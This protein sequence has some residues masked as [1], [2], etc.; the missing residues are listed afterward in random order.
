M[1]EIICP[2]FIDLINFC[3]SKIFDCFQCWRDIFYLVPQVHLPIFSVWISLISSAKFVAFQEVSKQYHIAACKLCCCNASVLTTFSNRLNKISCPL[4]SWGL[5]FNSSELKCNHQVKGFF[6]CQ[7]R[8][9]GDTTNL[10]M[11]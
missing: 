4:V 3:H 10:I 5:S 2:L 7:W 8:L 11:L 6:L 9:W 1:Q